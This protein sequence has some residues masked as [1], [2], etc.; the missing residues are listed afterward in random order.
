M[1]ASGEDAFHVRPQVCRQRLQL[2]EL[3]EPKHRVEGRAQLVAQPGDEQ[4]CCLAVAFGG[5]ALPG[6]HPVPRDEH[7]AAFRDG[8]DGQ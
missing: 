4:V 2:E 1:P 5:G 8:T 6:V 3:G 7:R